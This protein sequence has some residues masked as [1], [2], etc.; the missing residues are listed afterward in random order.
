MFQTNMNKIA[1][2]HNEIQHLHSD[3]KGYKENEDRVKLQNSFN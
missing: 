1:E 3:A 2:L